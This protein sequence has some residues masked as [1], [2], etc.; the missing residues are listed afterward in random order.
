[1]YVKVAYDSFDNKRR[2]DDDDNEVTFRTTKR[3]VTDAARFWSF[4]SSAFLSCA[5]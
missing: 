4:R 5:V 1:M 3:K 2:Y